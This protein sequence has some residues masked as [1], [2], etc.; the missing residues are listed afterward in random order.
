MQ[1]G[2]GQVMNWNEPVIRDGMVSDIQQ[3]VDLLKELF[4]IEADFQFDESIQYSGLQMFLDGCGKHRCVRVA[5]IQ[6]RLVGMCTAQTLIST[7]EGGI[8]ALIEDL[9]VNLEYRGRGI[10]TKLLQS[11]ET[12]AGIR[13]IRRI[14]LLA[15]KNNQTGLNFYAHQKWQ[16]TEL[17]C[18]RKRI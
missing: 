13:G 8:V 2:E 12:W 3:M 10:G 11:V 9:V 18:L 7:A 4:M 1:E 16:S 5:G 6:D 14:Q 17:I 15:D